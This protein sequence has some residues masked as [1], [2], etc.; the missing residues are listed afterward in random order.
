M[1]RTKKSRE[2]T[3]C[4]RAFQALANEALL[5]IVTVAGQGML[6]GEKGRSR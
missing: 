2:I 1:L 4:S 6:V 3:S 5:M